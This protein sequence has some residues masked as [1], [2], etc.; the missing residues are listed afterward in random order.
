MVKTHLAKLASNSSLDLV[1]EEDHL[2]WA[3]ATLF[4]GK[5]PG[6]AQQVYIS[7]TLTKL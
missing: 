2:K 5:K 4:G 1:D 7:L 3:S 6:F